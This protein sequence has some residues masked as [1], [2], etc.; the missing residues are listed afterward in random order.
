MLSINW[1]MLPSTLSH[2]GRREV[3]RLRPR[4]DQLNHHRQYFATSGDEVSGR[5]AG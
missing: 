3:H 5:M 2:F 1:L 4:V